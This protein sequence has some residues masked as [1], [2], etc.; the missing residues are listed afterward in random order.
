MEVRVLRY[1]LAVAEEGNITWAAQL[2]RISQPTLSRQLRQLEEDLGVALFDRG[3]RTLTLTDAGRLLRERAQTIVSL[4]DKTEF[5]LRQSDSEL[6]GDIVIG[7]G[8]MRAMSFLSQRMVAFRALHPHVHF[9]VIS[10][11]AD[12]IQNR[13]EQGLMDFGLLSEPA[14]TSRYEC[15]ATGIAEQWAALVPEH[16]PLANR[17]SL[18]PQDLEEQTLLLPSRE[19]VRRTVLQWFGSAADHLDVAG[20]CNLPANG[21]NMTANGMGIYICLDLGITYPGIRTVPLDPPLGNASVLAWKRQKPSSPPPL[22]RL[23]DS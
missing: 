8:E 19:S 6:S 4:T 7:C 10:T 16:H 11:T 13:I 21:A 22:R 1:F 2:L 23:H 18:S 12:V 17:T 5:E 15:I 9:Q 20:W 14:D 3:G